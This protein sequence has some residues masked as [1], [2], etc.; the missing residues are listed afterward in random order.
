MSSGGV[1][2][3]SIH[4]ALGK[5]GALKGGGQELDIEKKKKKKKKKITG[6]VKLKPAAFMSKSALSW[7]LTSFG[8]C[9]G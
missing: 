1:G 3:M 4:Y 6:S 7:F 2:S 8:H 9:E 5:L